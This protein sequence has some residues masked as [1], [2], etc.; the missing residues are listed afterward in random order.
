MRHDPRIV[1][2]ESQIAALEKSVPDWIRRS[3]R[4]PTPS[5]MPKFG[6]L[7][8]IRAVGTGVWSRNL[9]SAPSSPNLVPKSSMSSVMAA[10]RSGLPRRSSRVARV[11]IARMSRKSGRIVSRSD[12]IS[13]TS[14]AANF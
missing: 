2:N 11:R 4:P 7:E 5:P 6:P 14:A 13:S 3:Q 10:I 8:G 1:T 12:S 9:I